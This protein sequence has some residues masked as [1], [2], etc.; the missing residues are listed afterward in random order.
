MTDRRL[1]ENGS[2]GDFQMT[3]AMAIVLMVAGSLVVVACGA[4]TFLRYRK[5][6]DDNDDDD[7]QGRDQNAG[8]VVDANA[9]CIVAPGNKTIAADGPSLVA[10]VANSVP[11]TNCAMPNDGNH[12]TN[13]A[14]E[15]VRGNN[16]NVS[17]GGR[18]VV[19][20]GP[21]NAL[22]RER[23]GSCSGD[24]SAD[25]AC[26][27]TAAVV[28]PSRASPTSVLRGPATSNVYGVQSLQHKGS[29]SLPS[30]DQ[31]GGQQLAGR[32]SQAYHRNP[33]IIPAPLMSPAGTTYSNHNHKGKTD[34]IKYIPH[35]FVFRV[36]VG[37]R[38]VPG[39]IEECVRNL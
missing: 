22:T 1:Q 3:R 39:C 30:S 10:G 37:K 7:G 15:D 11:Q 32:V 20:S 12:K 2:M 27:Q 19:S 6:D 13:T 34:S 36:I 18:V 31:P 4:A 23:T 28:T 25:V 14:D 8:M 5:D 26:A 9:L 33:D 38:L 35:T 24:G 16:A 21:R 17:G 29:L